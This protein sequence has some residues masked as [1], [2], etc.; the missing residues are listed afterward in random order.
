MQLRLRRRVEVPQGF[1]YHLCAAR[2]GAAVQ[3]A[4]GPGWFL[5]FF[6][7]LRRLEELRFG[8]AS[9]RASG[10]LDV[11]SDQF[12]IQAIIMLAALSC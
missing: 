11:S 1:Y 9:E 4:V 2:R 8:S 7:R 12:L 10:W 5:S 3:E 6:L